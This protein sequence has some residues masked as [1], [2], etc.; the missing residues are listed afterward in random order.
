[1][2]CKNNRQIKLQILF[3][4]LL[5]L[6]TIFVDGQNL[7]PN[8]DFEKHNHLF[9]LRSLGS[10]STWQKPNYATPD[11]K[12]TG[13]IDKR[14]ADNYCVGLHLHLHKGNTNF[15]KYIH[16]EY[17][18]VKLSEKLKANKIY[19][20]SANVLHDHNDEYAAPYLNFSLTPKAITAKKDNKMF[21]NV[22][23]YN[24]D[25]AED[26]LMRDKKNWMYVC[27]TIQANGN[28][29]YFTI[30]YFDTAMQ[31][32]PVVKKHKSPFLDTYY[33]IDNISL[34]EI[35]D[36]SACDCQY[37]ADK[38]I[39]QPIKTDTLHIGDQL[40]LK[41]VFF[42]TNKSD[43]LPEST[44]ALQSLLKAM[45]SNPNLMIE[46]IGYTDNIGSE[47]KNTL[48]SENRA[49]A[50]ANYLIENGIAEQRIKKAGFG[51]SNPI[52][53]NNTEAGRA[54]NRRIEIKILQ[55]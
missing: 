47:E 49:I 10:L 43:L 18:Q 27:K 41:K 5:V 14:F 25:Y 35:T 13:I 22:P 51:S 33:Y 37:K 39:V 31:L 19:C 36:S 8:G 11:Y 32:T 12:Y 28:E 17:V 44:R 3:A 40:I 15:N 34:V 45:E 16:V 55:K 9:S 50:V 21:E 30:G 26:S 6:Q 1:M 42:A 29:K 23:Y 38:P 46:I 20:L 4:A 53:D 7:I 24:L 54:L 52:G 48:L 2:A